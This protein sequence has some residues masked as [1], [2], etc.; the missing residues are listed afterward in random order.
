MRL[1][2]DAVGKFTKAELAFLRTRPF[3]VLLLETLPLALLLAVA[4]W[5]MAQ[6]CW[7]AGQY[8]PTEF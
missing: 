7:S 5:N 3:Q 4:M 2:G 6:Y 8:C 1:R